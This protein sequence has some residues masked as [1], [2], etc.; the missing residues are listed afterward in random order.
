MQ[1]KGL[2]T[3]NSGP[4]PK[5]W[6]S[7]SREGLFKDEETGNNLTLEVSG[8]RGSLKGTRANQVLFKLEVSRRRTGNE[9]RGNQFT[10][11][12]TGNLESQTE[13]PGNE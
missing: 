5:N 12:N 11:R 9:E 1:G 13:V 7:R 10:G 2:R 8:R 6:K 3:R 4:D